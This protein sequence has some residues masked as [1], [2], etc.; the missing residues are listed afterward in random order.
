M[1]NETIQENAKVWAQRFGVV[2]YRIDGKYMIYNISYPTNLMT[3]VKRYTIQHV[4]NLETMQQETIKPLQKFDKSGL[5]NN[6]YK[7]DNI[8]F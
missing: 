8:F 2:T 4:I 6:N 5:K 1:S 7:C 3:G